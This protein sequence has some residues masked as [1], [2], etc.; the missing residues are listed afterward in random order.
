MAGHVQRGLVDRRGNNRIDCSPP[1]ELHGPCYTG[2]CR[3]PAASG[4][5][6]VTDGVALWIADLHESDIT[7]ENE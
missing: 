4:R 3:M 2:K 5:L 6:R 1:G 7:P